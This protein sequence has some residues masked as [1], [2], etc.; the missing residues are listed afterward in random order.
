MKAE[1]DFPETLQEA[2]RYFADKARAFAYITKVRWPDGKVACPRC[3]SQDVSFIS[4]RHLWT[5]KACKVKKQFTP[6]IGTVLEDSAIPYDKWICAFWMVANC[7]NGISSYEVGR[8]LGVT[9]RTGWFMLQRIRLALQNGTIVKLSGSVEV[10][11][12]FIGANSRKMNNKQKA[13]R[14][15]KG[16]GPWNLT[17]V[18]GL[19]ERGK[20]GKASRVILKQV[21]DNKKRTLEPNVRE[22]ILKGSEV[23]TD[24]HRGYE[25]IDDEYTHQVINHAVSYVK[26]HVHTQGIDNFWSLLK[27]TIR[28]TYVSVEPFHLFRYLDEQA[29]RFNERKDTNGDKGRFLKAM[30]GIVGKRLTW[31]KLTA[32]IDDAGCLPIPA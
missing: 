21:P 11:E 23:H 17:P 25:D 4:T 24:E 10:D 15:H 6:R 26:G 30:A 12:S 20:G 19:L 28:G 22:Y 9:Q 7:K 29:F 3:G 18:Q 8:S 5:C 14:K 27:R 16:T 31:D 13:K 32:K 1:T 2:I